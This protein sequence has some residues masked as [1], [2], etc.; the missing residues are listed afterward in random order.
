M[1]VLI[2]EPESQRAHP[3]EERLRRVGYSVEIAAEPGL[4]L[5]G[6]GVQPGYDL[7]VIDVAPLARDGLATVRAVRARDPRVPLLLIT[8]PDVAERIRGLDLGADDCLASPFDVEELLARMR[9]LLRRGPLERR[10][11][12]RVADLVLDPATRAARRGAR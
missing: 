4:A 2:L 3:L 10:A 11:L 7:A 5:A 6:L 8:G 12:L 1:R 9:A